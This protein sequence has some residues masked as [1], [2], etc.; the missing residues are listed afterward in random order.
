MSKIWSDIHTH[1]QYS[2]ETLIDF[3]TQIFDQALEEHK[4]RDNRAGKLTDLGLYKFADHLVSKAT[5]LNASMAFVGYLHEGGFIDESILI[6]THAHHMSGKAKNKKLISQEEGNIFYLDPFDFKST[7][8]RVLNTLPYTYKAITCDGV[9]FEQLHKEDIPY[10][11]ILS[12]LVEYA[13]EKYDENGLYPFYHCGLYSAAEVNCC[14]FDN[15]S[16]NKAFYLMYKTSFGVLENFFKDN[17]F[18]EIEPHL[19]TDDN[20]ITKKVKRRIKRYYD[21]NRKKDYSFGLN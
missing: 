2:F 16:D 5:I 4:N 6:Q 14:L 11:G 3:A 20:H 21:V 1:A 7:S 12:S 9:P 10:F 17:N 8:Q 18:A 19:T 15:F 13:H